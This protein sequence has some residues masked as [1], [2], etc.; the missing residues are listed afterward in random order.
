MKF[1][2]NNYYT[3]LVKNYKFI[4]NN[5]L[6]TNNEKNNLIKMISLNYFE[7]MVLFINL[8]I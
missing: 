5:I 4:K 6:D 2:K 7:L 3:K 1:S 8:I